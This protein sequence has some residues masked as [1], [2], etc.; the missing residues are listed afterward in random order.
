LRR[1]KDRVYH[2]VQQNVVLGLTLSL[3]VI[4][5]S[6]TVSGEQQTTPLRRVSPT[7]YGRP[8]HLYNHTWWPDRYRHGMKPDIGRK[9]RFLCLPP[10]AFDAVVRVVFAEY[11][12][13]VWYAIA[14]MVRLYPTMNRMKMCLLLSTEYTNVTDG[15]TDRRTDRHR[16]T[17]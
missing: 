10:P 8:A 5:T 4:N 16:T 7:C 2:C 13:N 15:R 11:C 17:A 6:S 14:Q 3:L 12:H 9:S 1:Q